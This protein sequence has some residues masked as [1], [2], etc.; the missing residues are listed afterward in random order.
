MYMYPDIEHAK[1]AIKECGD[2]IS[3]YGLPSELC[4]FTVVVTGKRA[5]GTRIRH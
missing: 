1:A 5:Q 4:P 2:A 3:L